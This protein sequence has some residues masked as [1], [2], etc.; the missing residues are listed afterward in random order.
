M[1][2]KGTEEESAEY[3]KL[4]MSE[5]LTGDLKAV[6]ELMTDVG[7]EDFP[8]RFQDLLQ[9]VHDFGSL[10]MNFGSDTNTRP[11]PG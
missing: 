6:S 8:Q 3:I 4:V 1:T 7:T 5:N 2:I 10:C 11:D 9:Q